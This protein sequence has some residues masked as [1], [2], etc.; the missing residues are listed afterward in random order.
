M[1]KR[2]HALLILTFV[3]VSVSTVSAQ[4]VP[5][6]RQPSSPVAVH[7]KPVI[8]Y[9]HLPEDVRQ[10]MEANKAAGF[11]VYSG[12]QKRYL[13]EVK[14]ADATATQQLLGFLQNHAGFI[15]TEFISPGRVNVV[16]APLH[17]P[18]TLKEALRQHN[19]SFQFINETVF[20]DN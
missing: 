19:I 10:K 12:I 6:T 3:L 1:I 17:D 18:V 14:V 7:P 15:K 4:T 20:I 13:I 11:D 2:L 9:E 8:S 5:A 16:V